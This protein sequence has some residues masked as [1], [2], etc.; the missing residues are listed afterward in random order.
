MGCGLKCKL[1]ERVGQSV[2]RWYGQI[3][4]MSEQRLMKE[5]RRAGM[6]GTRGTGRLRTI[7]HDG[8]IKVLGERD[9]TIL[10]VE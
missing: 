10:Q 2:M 9:M 8:M 7:R 4:R 5:I 3:E 6:D 1:N